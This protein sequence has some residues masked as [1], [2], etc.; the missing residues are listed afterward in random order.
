M[1]IIV[2]INNTKHQAYKFVGILFQFVK[3]LTAEGTEGK[4]SRVNFLLGRAPSG[5]AFRYKS[6]L[7]SSLWAFRFN[8]SRTLFTNVLRPFNI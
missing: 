3:Y 7:A 4:I 8:P 2:F 1:D 6:S 5:R